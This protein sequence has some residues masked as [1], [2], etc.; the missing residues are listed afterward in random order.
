M[1]LRVL[2]VDEVWVERMIALVDGPWERAPVEALL[3]AWG[4]ALPGEPVEW[5]GGPCAPQLSHEPR[6]WRIELGAAPPEP[7]LWVHLPCALYWP[8]FGELEPDGHDGRHEFDEDLPP[9]WTWRPDPDRAALHAERDRLTALITARLGAPELVVTGPYDGY[10][11]VWRR[12]DRALLLEISDDINSYS[13]FDVL[14]IRLR[15]YG[16]SLAR[17]GE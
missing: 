11:A 9:L 1:S 15:P 6:G 10:R 14:G 5:E 4:L 3:V 2:P 13:E 12:G 16:P 7:D 8:P 17:L